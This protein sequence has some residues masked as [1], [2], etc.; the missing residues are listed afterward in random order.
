MAG[1]PGLTGAAGWTEEERR[2]P[3][4]DRGMGSDAPKLFRDPRRDAESGFSRLRECMRESVS[5]MEEREAGTSMAL[6]FSPG[7]TVMLAAEEC[8]CGRVGGW[9]GQRED[10]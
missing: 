5:A 9:L 8:C 4:F 10:R 1:M 2:E 7:M 3:R 6:P